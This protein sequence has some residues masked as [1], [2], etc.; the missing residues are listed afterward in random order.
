MRSWRP[1]LA[2]DRAPQMLAGLIGHVG[3]PAFG[4]S[5]LDD[6]Q[7]LLPAAS[8]SVYRAG[9][10]AA[11]A[12]YL[13]ASRGVADTT[14]DCWRAYLSGPHRHDRILQRM[15]QAA[16]GAPQLCHITADEVP[17]EHRAKVY[18]AHGMAERVSVL[19]RQAGGAVFAINFYRHRH[20]RPFTDAAL[21][22]FGLLAPVLLALVR[23]HIAL[24]SAQPQPSSPSAP[25]EM[26]DA[27]A[28][29]DLRLQRLCPA[30]TERERAV[31]GRMLQGMTLE[32]IAADLGLALPTVK[33]Y[34][35]RAFDRLGIHFRNELF[36]RVLAA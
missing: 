7:E 24:G 16:P 36:A 19:E 30:L 8:W 15:E 5:M 17:R 33:T 20:Q 9:R 2:T 32:G 29:F 14:R 6:V 13:S 23:K 3:E 22:A 31:C 11:P 21:D 26:P 25:G 28:G 27:R 35:G 18:E 12:L 1:A 10:T 34:R 4:Q